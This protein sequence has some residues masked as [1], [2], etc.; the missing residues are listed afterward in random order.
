MTWSPVVSTIYASLLQVTGN[1]KIFLNYYFRIIETLTT[2]PDFICLNGKG[3]D[4]S[5]WRHEVDKSLVLP[6]LLSQKRAKPTGR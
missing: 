3:S 6:T 5:S 1:V 4:Q 2:T